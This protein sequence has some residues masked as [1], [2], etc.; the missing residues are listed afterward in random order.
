ML[1]PLKKPRPSRNC[2]LTSL[3]T[4]RN[5][6]WT[7]GLAPVLVLVHLLICTIRQLCPNIIDLKIA[8]FYPRPTCLNFTHPYPRSACPKTTCLYRNAIY[9]ETTR[10][11]QKATYSKTMHLSLRPG[12]AHR[13]IN[14]I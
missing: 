2:E 14:S 1:S 11:S 4:M 10:L 8:Y 12:S 13:P 9:S 5:A 6:Y 3:D 7:L